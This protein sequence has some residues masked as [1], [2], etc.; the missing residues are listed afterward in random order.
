M[1]LGRFYGNCRPAPTI[2]QILAGHGRIAAEPGRL[3]V[4]CKFDFWIMCRYFESFWGE[5][6]RDAAS[7][8][9]CR[10]DGRTRR[11][12]V[13]APASRNRSGRRMAATSCATQDG[14]LPA[15]PFET[16]RFFRLLV[17]FDSAASFFA[18]HA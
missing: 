6:N 14:A 16:S 11:V 10:V 8:S 2:L 17:S 12:P 13:S 4:K 1:S 15:F 7:P 9:V 3:V 18:A 5:G